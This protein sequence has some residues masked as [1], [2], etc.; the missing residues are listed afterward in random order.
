MQEA[1]AAAPNGAAEA[2]QRTRQFERHLD[3]LVFGDSREKGIVR[4]N[5]FVH[6]ILRF[7]LRFPEGW[8][9]STATS[10]SPHVREKDSNVG[11]AA[12]DLASG[13]GSL[14]QLAPAGHGRKRA[15]SRTSTAGARINGLDA[16]VGTL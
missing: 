9:S 2:T 13:T 1:V 14:E 3:G 11:D 10:R 5:E 7:A 16:Y 12:A 8:R 15:C 6:P 4:G